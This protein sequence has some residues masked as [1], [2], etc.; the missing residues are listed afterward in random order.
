LIVTL[1]TDEEKKYKKEEKRIYDP[2]ENKFN[3]IY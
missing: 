2:L 1:K 3:I